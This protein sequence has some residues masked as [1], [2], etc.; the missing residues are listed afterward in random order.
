MTPSERVISS[1]R[2]ARRSRSGRDT[3]EPTG[4]ANIDGAR[5]GNAGFGGVT[6]AVRALILSAAG[7][8]TPYVGS[9]DDVSRTTD[10]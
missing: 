10:H 9:D 3:V 6:A 7:P 4:D 8:G 5:I 2:A 1:A